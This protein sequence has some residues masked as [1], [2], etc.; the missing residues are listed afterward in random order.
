[1]AD[2]TLV[3][4]ARHALACALACGAVL[5]LRPLLAWAVGVRLAYLAW[6]V[7]PLAGAAAA[8]PGARPAF[9][10]AWVATVPVPPAAAE[11]ARSLAPAAHALAASSTSLLALWAG[12]AVLV[13]GVAAARAW[14]FE[15]DLDTGRVATQGAVTVGLLRPRLVL[16]P[17]FAS[18]HD[19]AERA[20]VFA[21]EAV[22]ARRRDNAWNLFALLL[23]AIDWFDPL[24]WLALARF[25]RDQELSCDADVLQARGGDPEARRTYAHALARA[26]VADAPFPLATPWRPDHPLLERIRM[27]SAP[28]PS[29]LRHRAGQAL[30]AA[31][32]AGGAAAAW[33]LQPAG[34]EPAAANVRMEV[35]LE[36]DGHAPRHLVLLGSTGQAMRVTLTPDGADPAP[37]PVTFEFV[38][39][40]PAPH[41]Y[42]VVTSID[43]GASAK[44]APVKLEQDEGARTEARLIL[45]LA[46]G[47]HTFGLHYVLRHA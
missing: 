18:R 16:P 24:A 32:V 21:H 6:L 33:A 14:R 1:M 39:D 34:A 27:L 5:A 3:L 36:I 30:V 22:H 10:Q 2:D 44:G 15:H 26:A 42:A 20:L 37:L 29:R 35:D 40:Q 31:L 13:L 28:A 25:R 4:L 12:G 9:T 11:A 19:A 8:W 7:V 47:R 46:D 43:A 45:D 17:D 41:R 23:L 38:V